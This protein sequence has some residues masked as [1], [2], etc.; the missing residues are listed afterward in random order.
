MYSNRSQVWTQS[1]AGLDAL[2]Y[3]L[4]DRLDQLRSNSGTDTEC[5]N[6]VL[7]SRDLP[8]YVLQ[9]RG[10]LR[11]AIQENKESEAVDTEVEKI[12]NA[13]ANDLW[14]SVMRQYRRGQILGDIPMMIPSRPVATKAERGMQ[15]SQTP[16]TTLSAEKHKQH[17]SDTFAEINHLME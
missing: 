10:E 1:D 11:N 15:T 17:V 9:R 14:F 3:L 5:L 6:R 2:E 8:G 7:A 4:N 16:T 12:V 13:W